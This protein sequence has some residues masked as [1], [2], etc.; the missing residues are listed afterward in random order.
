LLPELVAI[1][2]DGKTATIS[3][4]IDATQVVCFI[5]FFISYPSKCLLMLLIIHAKDFDH[6]STIHYLHYSLHQGIL[7]PLAEF[8]TDSATGSGYGSREI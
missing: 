4:I 7:Y 1:T 8:S 6:R 5:Q 3:A 2:S